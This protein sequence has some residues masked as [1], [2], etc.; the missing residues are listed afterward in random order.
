MKALRSDFECVFVSSDRDEESF[1]DY[2]SKKMSF[3]ALPYAEHR[4]TKAALSKMFGVSG[5]P[6]LVML[7]PADEGGARPLINANMRSFIDSGE[8]SAFPFHKKNYGDV[9][10]SEELNEVK[11]LIIFCENGDDE[12]QDEIKEIVKQVA[13]KLAENKEEEKMNVHWVVSP[14]GI[15]TQIRS[16]TKLPAPNM[17]LDP[18]MVLLDI[19]EQGAYYKSDVTDITVENVMKFLD[20]PGERLQ[21]GN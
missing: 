2:F 15:G 9:N 4:D 5:I 6:A 3:C 8:F 10:D 17:S 18:I 16:L 14:K 21:L 19:P 13:A 20:C 1:N 12:E 7:G 11:S